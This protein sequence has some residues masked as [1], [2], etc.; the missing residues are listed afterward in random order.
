MKA[1]RQPHL[2]LGI[3]P[4]PPGGFE[5]FLHRCEKRLANHQTRDGKLSE[6]LGSLLARNPQVA[7]LYQVEV[8]D[9]DGVLALKCLDVAGG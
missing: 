8:T 4:A 1:I 2:S 9:K 5:E 3:P 7:D 6:A